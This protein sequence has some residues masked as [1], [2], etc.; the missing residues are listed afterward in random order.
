MGGM[1]SS[2]KPPAPQPIPEPAEDNSDEVQAE[3]KRARATRIAAN[4]FAATNKTGLLSSTA[5][6]QKKK[7][8]GSVS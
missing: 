3:E 2:P 4:G 6:T 7:A 8:L 5:P 1:F